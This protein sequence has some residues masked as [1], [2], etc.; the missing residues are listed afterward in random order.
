MLIP[1]QIREM[2]EVETEMINSPLEGVGY[3]V[4]VRKV[5]TERGG[6]NVKLRHWKCRS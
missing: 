1:R 6:C 3:N 2:L 5:E 4:E